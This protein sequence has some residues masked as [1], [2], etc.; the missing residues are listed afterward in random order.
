MILKNPK[1]SNVL[2]KL[3]AAFQKIQKDSKS[4]K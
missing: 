2:E 1:I 3:S 4:S